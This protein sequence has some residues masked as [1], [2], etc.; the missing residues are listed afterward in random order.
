MPPNIAIGEEFDFTVTEGKTITLPCVVEGD[1]KPQITWT[2]NGHRIQ[3]AD[4]HYFVNAAGSLEVF[5]VNHLDSATYI[6]TAINI[7]GVADKR[8]TLFVQ[9]ESSLL[10]Y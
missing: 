3:D 7:A 9:S 10:W 8:M 5:S 4:P 1:P 2:K 6:C